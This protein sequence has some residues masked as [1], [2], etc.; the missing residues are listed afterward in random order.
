[1]C[2]AL[3]IQH[4]HILPAATSMPHVLPLPLAALQLLLLDLTDDSK[5]LVLNLRANQLSGNATV[6]ESCGS[7]VS[8]DISDNE[9]SGPLPASEQW[10]ELASYRVC[11]NRFSGSFPLKLTTS[12]RILEVTHM[13][14]HK[15][16]IN[17]CTCSEY[18]AGHGLHAWRW[19]ICCAGNC[20]LAMLRLQGW[21]CVQCHSC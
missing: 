2:R 15:V 12:A 10:E 4:C 14:L 5:L 13:P 18:M 8:L 11:H 19:A 9:F 6:V 3:T 21:Q 17:V 1:M 20:G 16:C 7:L